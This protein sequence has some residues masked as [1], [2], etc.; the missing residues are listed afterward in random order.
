VSSTWLRFATF[1]L[2]VAARTV[3]GSILSECKAS[4]MMPTPRRCPGYHSH[5]GARQ[6]WLEALRG[7]KNPFTAQVLDELRKQ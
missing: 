2:T 5:R 1:R 7:D 6:P 4:A 3:T